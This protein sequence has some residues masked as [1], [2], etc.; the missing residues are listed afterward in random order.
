MLENAC[1][2]QPRFSSQGQQS[3]VATALQQLACLVINTGDQSTLEPKKTRFLAIT[4]WGN[5]SL[6]SV[7]VLTSSEDIAGVQADPGLQFG[8]RVR[9]LLL[10]ANLPLGNSRGIQVSV[11]CPH[12]QQLQAHAAVLALLP[13]KIDEFVVAGNNDQILRGSL[14]GQAAVPKASQRYLGIQQICLPCQ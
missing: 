2:T 3:S 5:V 9:L 6:W 12:A 4:D 7:H 14:Y 13:N 8:G 10:A 1:Q 11:I